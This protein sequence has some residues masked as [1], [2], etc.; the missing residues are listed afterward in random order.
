MAGDDPGE[1]NILS[2]I[3]TISDAYMSLNNGHFGFLLCTGLA[4]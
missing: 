2:T 1:Y 4:T 3:S